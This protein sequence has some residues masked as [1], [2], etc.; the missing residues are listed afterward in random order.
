[1]KWLAKRDEVTVQEEMR[2]L[3][4]LQLQEEQDLYIDEFEQ[5]TGIDFRALAERD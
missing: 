3:F 1:M 2:Q 5:E 4:Y